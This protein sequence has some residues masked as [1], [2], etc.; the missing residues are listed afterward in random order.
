M[1]FIWVEVEESIDLSEILE[2]CQVFPNPSPGQT[3]LD[4]NVGRPAEASAYGPAGRSY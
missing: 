2:S 4:F 3:H 1:A